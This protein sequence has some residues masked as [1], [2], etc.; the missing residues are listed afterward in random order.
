MNIFR[1]LYLSISKKRFYKPFHPFKLPKKPTH[2]ISAP[3]NIRDFLKTLFFLSGLRNS[4]TIVIV[5]QKS[6]EN[7]HRF[8]K[9]NIFEAIFYDKTPLL[10]S[11]EYKILEERLNRRSF[12][13][14]IE[15]NVPANISLP[16]LTNAE[17]RI[18][19]DKKSNFPYY[20][21]FMKDGLNVL[22]EFFHI[23]E[24]NPQ[25]LFDFKER[26][27]RK[28]EQKFHKNRPLL[29]L[30][31]K[32]DTKWDGDKVAVGKDILPSDPES[33]QV[34]YL[35]DAYCGEHDGF[36]E[37]AKIFNKQIIK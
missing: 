30:N 33:F 16:Y 12:N 21:I 3:N 28:V 37:F 17:K 23:Q 19:L 35:A 14:L 2:L 18:C 34:L 4:G 20:N 25:D 26:D 11:K 24:S 31:R 6:L 8:F 36:Y 22:N 27:L 5:M 1:P 10:F 7:I 29:F 32:D 9:K 13:F 15:L